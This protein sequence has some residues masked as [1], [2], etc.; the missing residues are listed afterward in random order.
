MVDFHSD[1]RKKADSSSKRTFAKG[2]RLLQRYDFQRL[3]KTGRRFQNSYFIAYGCINE[4]N[5][6]RLGITVTRRVG[7]SITRN[8]I[9]RL[10]REY[11]RQNR[12]IF[13]EKWDISIIAKQQAADV[14]NEK[15]SMFLE[16]IFG[17]IAS[18]KSN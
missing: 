7:K 13:R 14:P 1:R 3:R 4:L 15:L 5:R 2:D 18:F 11:F 16:D 8:R 12:Q 10:A 9:K 17:R 6:C